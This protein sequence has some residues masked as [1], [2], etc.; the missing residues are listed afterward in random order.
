MSHVTLS[1]PDESRV[2]LTPPLNCLCACLCC[3]LG[4]SHPHTRLVPDLSGGGDPDDAFGIVPYEKGFY[5][6]Y[7]LQVRC[8]RAYDVVCLLG[9]H[10]LWGIHA[11]LGGARVVGEDPGCKQYS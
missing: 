10:T 2:P 11:C 5:F 6:L 3:S 8:A 9:V 4:A 1:L 7:Y